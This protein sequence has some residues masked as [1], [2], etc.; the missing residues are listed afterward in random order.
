[1]TTESDK[2]YND[3]ELKH[4]G[5]YTTLKAHPPIPMTIEE[6]IKTILQL[7]GDH[8]KQ[9]QRERINQILKMLREQK[10]VQ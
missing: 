9:P 6:K 2:Y 10:G 4:D 1:M 3:P 7:L 8:L 5:I